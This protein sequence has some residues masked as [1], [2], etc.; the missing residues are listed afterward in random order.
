MR[1]ARTSFEQVTARGSTATAAE[2]ASPAMMVAATAREALVCI[3]AGKNVSYVKRS[4]CLWLVDG[5]LVLTRDCV[6]KRV[7]P[8]NE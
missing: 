7:E 8:G 4:L 2:L 5:C 6:L 3:F 1:R